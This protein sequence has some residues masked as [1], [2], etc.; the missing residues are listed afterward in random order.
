[1]DSNIPLGKEV[2]YISTYKPELLFPVP[3]ALGRQA[4]SIQGE[5]PFSGV[6]IW[7]AYE[8]SWLDPGGKPRVA[9]A[10][11]VFSVQSVNI[12][13]SKSLKLYL[14]SFNQT[15]FHSSEEVSQVIQEDLEKVS[16]GEVRITLKL[17]GSF[18][19]YRL[20]EPCNK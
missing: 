20:N 7:N 16:L 8:I 10:E 6:D 19:G 9:I 11:I 2:S 4:I 12:I 18:E 13:E 5:L 14:N 3:R 1:M 17:P 15:C